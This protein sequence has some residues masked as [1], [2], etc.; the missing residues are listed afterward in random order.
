MDPILL[1]IPVVSALIGWGTNALAIRM[2]FSPTERKGWGVFSWQGVLPSH[3]ERMAKMCVE[4]MTSRLLDVK[5]V[6]SRIDAEKVSEIIGPT[7]EQHTEAIV[8]EVIAQHY[9]KLWAKM[10]ERLREKGRQRLRAEIPKVVEKLIN[11]LGENL[12]DYLDVESLVVDSFVRDRK[13]VN[14]LFWE[15]GRNEFL[16]IARSGLIF[17]GLFGS[18]QAVIWH[19]TQPHW[20]L[21]VTGLLVGW[22]TNWLALKMVFEPLEPKRIFGLKWQGLFLRRQKEV[23][24]AYARFFATRILH[25]E[26]LVTAVLTGPAA[27]QLI[28]QVKIYANESVDQ[29][30]GLARPL[31]ALASGSSDWDGLKTEISGRLIFVVPQALGEVHG[32]AEEALDLKESLES[33]LRGL[34]PAE[35]E[36]V[37][38]PIFQE[39]ENTLIAV[40]AVLGAVAG[41]IQFL[42]VT[43]L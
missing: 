10:P 15:C 8:E 18:I 34:P 7:L 23:S 31:M 32:Y 43:S 42:A 27:E 1:I 11:E 5:Q 38:R 28:D 13:L 33:N 21:P 25:P 2:L 30:A 37:L 17:G 40:G 3:A 6:F 9:P 36:G 22:A 14:E 26:A 29:A 12:D 4:L 35:F 19:F 20:F 41:T 39:D 24:E 16:F